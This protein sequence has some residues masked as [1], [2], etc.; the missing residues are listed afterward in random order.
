M[1]NST[2]NQ[3]TFTAFDVETTGLFPISGRILEIAAVKFTDNGEIIDTFSQLVDPNCPIPEDA[4]RI[5]GITDGM[6]AGKPKIEQVLPEF[7]NFI[8]SDNS[9]L[10]AHNAKFDIGFIAISLIMSKL[11]LPKHRI[12]CTLELTQ[13]LSLP[14]QNHKLETLCRHFRIANSQ[15]HRAL[16]DAEL[17]YKLL[18]ELSKRH[19]GTD[20]LFQKI[21]FL[22]FADGRIAKV[23]SPPGFERMANALAAEL[24]IVMVYDGGTKGLTPRKITPRSFIEQRGK[25]YLIGFCHVDKTDKT[26]AL[27]RIQ[28]FRESTN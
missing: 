9:L 19:A 22:T 8:G 25:V 12:I 6:V 14:V 23:D 11:P 21:R 24:P 18:I 2:G 3:R 4:S 17:V 15:S 7:L 16:A 27:D 28:Q 13:S 10:L 26:F 1:M 5:N 20:G